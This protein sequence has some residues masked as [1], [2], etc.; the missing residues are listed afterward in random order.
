MAGSARAQEFEDYCEALSR[1]LLLIR[2]AATGGPAFERVERCDDLY[3]DGPKLRLLP[4]LLAEWTRD[5]EFQAI[6]SP[7]IGRVEG[8][9]QGVRTGDHRPEGSSSPPAPA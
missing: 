3:R 1:E 4:D 2:N 5:A 7:T 9:Y 8:R 6:E